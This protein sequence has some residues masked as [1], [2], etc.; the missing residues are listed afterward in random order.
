MSSRFSAALR[1][2]KFAAVIL[3]L[4]GLLAIGLIAVAGV[5]LYNKMKAIPAPSPTAVQVETQ[6]PAAASTSLPTSP[7]TARPSTTL[8]VAAP[9]TAQ[10]VGTALPTRPAATVGPTGAPTKLAPTAAPTT[11]PGADGGV[12]NTGASLLPALLAGGGFAALLVTARHG[13]RR[14]R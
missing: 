14:S 2:R 9:P 10:A 4:V 7:P 8:V 1:N 11:V 3:G 13:R 12:P 6:T 5:T